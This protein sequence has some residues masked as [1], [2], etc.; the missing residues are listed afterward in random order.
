MAAKD[1]LGRAGEKRAVAYLTARGFDILDRN[2]R[3]PSGEVDVVA[4]TGGNLVFVEVKTRRTDLF[5]DPLAAVDARKR[6]RI[7]G[8][9]HMWC[10][11][12]P[13][14]ARGRRCRLDVIG[15]TGS[16][17]ATARLEHMEDVPWV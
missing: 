15:I 13:A 5:G 3:A 11:A 7:W 12:H 6:A 16:D 9:A 1:E 17:P 4:C 8:L 10:A 2:W 14:D